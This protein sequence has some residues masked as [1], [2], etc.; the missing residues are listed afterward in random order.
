[1]P[2]L[3]CGHQV[4]SLL[5]V[6]VRVYQRQLTDSQSRNAERIYVG[7]DAE[8]GFC[9]RIV[10]ILITDAVSQNA[11]AHFVFRNYLLGICCCS[12]CCC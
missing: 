8:P 11:I 10:S 5:L 12:C 6:C 1:M 3:V 4:F 9:S 7:V 2:K